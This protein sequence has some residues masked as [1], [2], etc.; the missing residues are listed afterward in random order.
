MNGPDLINGIFEAGIAVFLWK[1]VLMLRVDKE[2]KGFYWPTVAW[3]AAWGLWNLFYYPHLGQWFS[4]GGGVAVVLVNITWLAHVAYYARGH[5]FF[6]WVCWKGSR[7]R[8]LYMA[9]LRRFR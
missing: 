7:C 6:D 2:V 3:T 9:L 5:I 4:F 8:A 1:G